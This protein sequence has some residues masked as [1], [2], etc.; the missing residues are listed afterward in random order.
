M[1]DAPAEFKGF[2]NILH[3]GKQDGEFADHPP[4]MKLNY[5]YKY[6]FTKMIMGYMNKYTWENQIQL[7]TIAAVE[8]ATDDQFVYIRRVDNLINPEPSFERVTVDRIA[9]TMTAE[10]IAMN[11]DGTE[12]V[13]QVHKFYVNAQQN[14]QNQFSVFQ[15]MDKTDM[16]EKYKQGIAN[17]VRAIKFSEMEQ[18]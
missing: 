13:L 9:N 12:S 5:T 4:I 18:E 3:R 17:V 10:G 8:Q 7:S 2:G 14:V 6:P 16:V 15:G 11:T 1:T